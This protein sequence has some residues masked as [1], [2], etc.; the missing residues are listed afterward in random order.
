MPP[1]IDFWQAK[2]TIYERF[3]NR[4]DVV[5]WESAWTFALQRCCSSVLL[6]DSLELSEDELVSAVKRQG[7][8]AVS[9]VVREEV[10]EKKTGGAYLPRSRRSSACRRAF[11]D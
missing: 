11:S 5:L 6:S 10:K 9:R 8:P 2:S 4:Q 1:V 7:L 3:I